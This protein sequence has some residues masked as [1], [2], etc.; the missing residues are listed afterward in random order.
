MASP[1]V[2]RTAAHRSSSAS[3]TPPPCVCRA[4]RVRSRARHVL[5]IEKDATFRTLCDA[6][7]WRAL[8]LILVTAQ[9]M[10][11]YATRA[12]LKHL[13][14]QLP[15]QLGFLGVVDWNP[16]GVL[17]LANYKAGSSKQCADSVECVT[18]PHVR[19]AQPAAEL[20]SSRG[21]DCFVSQLL[22]APWRVT[23]AEAAGAACAAWRC[24]SCSG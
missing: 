15:G 20:A 13:D 22:W 19:D 16:S 23:S 6:F 11:D 4:L 8:P 21:R 10:P 18:T 24:R 5:V 1:H 17:I 12:F 14:A 7:L 3:A 2:A 9:G